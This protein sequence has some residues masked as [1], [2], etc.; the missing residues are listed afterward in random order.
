MDQS[1]MK[2][3]ALAPW[4]GSKRNLAPV[5]VELIGDHRVYW[6]PFCGS[7]AVLLAKPPCVM[8]TVNDLHGDLI[9][10]ARVIKNGKLGP[11]LYRMLRRTMMCEVLFREAAERYHQRSYYMPLDEPDIDRAYD[12]F[13]C[14]WLGRNGV[15]GTASYNQGF[16]ARYTANGGH[17]AKRWESVIASMP[18]WRRR[19]TNVTIMQRDAF[20]ILAKIDDRKGT[21]IYVDP[22][23]FVKGAKYIHDFEDTDHKS[24]AAMLC[25]FK[26]T[27]VIVSYYDDERLDGMYPGW[28]RKEIIVSKAMANQGARGSK[29]VKV[30]EVLLVNWD[31]QKEPKQKEFGF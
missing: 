29:D 21:V 22:P 24:L 27:R 12:Y 4:F 6:E 25:R 23:Y 19:L 2:I 5:I 15:A 10:L 3:K 1:E 28:S 13:I 7:M 11:K 18:F 8:E 20:E 16:C 30:K 31:Q 9:N 14:A 26:E 17:A